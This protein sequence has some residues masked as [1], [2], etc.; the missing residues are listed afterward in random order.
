M[1]LILLS[2]R[3]QNDRCQFSILI[4]TRRTMGNLERDI[5]IKYVLIIIF[6]MIAFSLSSDII[7]ELL[8]FLGAQFQMLMRSDVRPHQVIVYLYI[9]L[10]LVNL[11]LNVFTALDN[12][13]FGKLDVL[14]KISDHLK[15]FLFDFSSFEIK[16]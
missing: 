12:L 3:F 11:I 5:K 4:R 13:P 15:A 14:L 1:L 9:F 16:S 2:L 7:D 10:Y 8:Y 6:S